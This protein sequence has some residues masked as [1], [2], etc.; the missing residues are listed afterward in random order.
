MH[1]PTPD[2]S[3]SS[4]P[5]G[6]APLSQ[7]E[8]LDRLQ[9][10]MYSEAT[11]Y[12]YKSYFPGD[13]STTL[14]PVNHEWREK[15]CQWTY[16]VVD[17]Y[18][19]PREIVAL[20]LDYFDRYLATRG[21][22]G[23]GTLALLVS[24]TTLHIAMKIHSSSGTFK[25][26]KLAE[27]SRGQFGPR[28]IEQMEWQIMMALSFKLHPP[29]L[30]QF[31]S[32]YL[33]LFPSEVSNIQATSPNHAVRKEL[34]EV[35]IYLAELSVCDSFFV[36]YPSSIISLAALSNVMD[37]MP[38]SKL[39][40]T[41]KQ[42]FWRCLNTY[43]GFHPQA[44]GATDR[45]QQLQEAKDRLRHMFHATSGSS[46]PNAEGKDQSQAN[47]I[48]GGSSIQS[49]TSLTSSPTSAAEMMAMEQEWNSEYCHD[50]KA[51]DHDD[52][53]ED[54][55]FRYSPSPPTT[56]QRHQSQQQHFSKYQQ[57]QQHYR[58][59]SMPSEDSPS[60]LQ[61]N[62]NNIFLSR[63]ASPATRARMACSPIVAGIQ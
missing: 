37:D 50:A 40:A 24:L 2:A 59:V 28:H 44:V 17:T 9:A 39:S 16:N 36:T 12:H 46:A 30:F 52:L 5:T 38:T 20:S 62:S 23:N 53:D 51:M 26:Q 18:D 63:A 45:L 60:I 35:S 58:R 34:F 4:S 48:S 11:G 21:N 10:M 6:A 43:L 14:R 41:A 42:E 54:V 57:H 8:V 47:H 7:D 49:T 27:L 3:A 31:V 13:E 32:Y 33:M 29:T 25:L 1:S 56:H 19:L 15:I 55:N 22:Q 61:S